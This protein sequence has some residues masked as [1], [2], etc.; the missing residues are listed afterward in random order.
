[1]VL[2]KLIMTSHYLGENEIHKTRTDSLNFLAVPPRN[3]A[4]AAANCEMFVSK[5]SKK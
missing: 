2:L 4:H 1:L 5:N 3:D